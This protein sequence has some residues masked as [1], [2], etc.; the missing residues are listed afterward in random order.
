MKNSKTAVQREQLEQV[1]KDFISINQNGRILYLGTPQSY[2][3]IY[4]GL[5]ARGFT[6]RIWPGRLPTVDQ[7]K[8][9]GD[10][11]A[12]LI[13]Q[14]C[15]RHPELLAGFGLDGK[16]G[17][18]TDP[19]LLPEDVLVSKE[20]DQGTIW[21]QL[22]H[23]L[24]TALADAQRH[25]LKTLNMIVMRLNSDQFPL[26]VVRGMTQDQVRKYQVCGQTYEFMAPHSVG[27][28]MAPLQARVMYI[29]PAAGGANGD[30]TA[31]AVVG[32]LNSNLFLLE[33]RGIPGGYTPDKL[34]AIAQ[35]VV[36]NKP[37]IL[38]IEKNMG[39]GAFREIV[40][41]VIKLACERAGVPCPAIEDDMVHGQKETRIIATL[42][43][44]IGRGSLIVSED[45]ILSET[46]TLEA[47]SLGKRVTYSLLHQL[48]KLTADKGSLHHDDRADAL[49][50]ACRH[51][52]PTLV[53]DQAKQIAA[54]RAAELAK[55]VRDPLGRGR[56]IGPQAPHS[57]SALSRMRRV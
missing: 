21:F 39:F 51:F 45:V 56:P 15:E 4:N 24:I 50:G 31:W 28:D 41:P 44:I 43:P 6:V 35:A 36:R 26:H 46:A 5:P 20:L 23:M 42:E 11:L 18:P 53:K 29:D 33:A 16:Q 27:S 8:H 47:Y 38:K 57:N 22:Q 55:F 3:S 30:E 52:V 37:G 13:R 40:V 54:L 32:M 2:Q 48:T 14:R 17:A 49:E 25:P 7:Q 34:N 10:M 9:Y 19:L 1:T 12:P